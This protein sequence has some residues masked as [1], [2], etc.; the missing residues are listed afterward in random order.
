VKIEARLTPTH[1]HSIVDGT[2]PPRCKCGA[3]YYPVYSSG[4]M[5]GQTPTFK[6]QPATDP[7]GW[8]EWV[9]PVMRGYKMQCCD[10]GL[11][12]EMEFNIATTDDGVPMAEPRVEFR[13]RRLSAPEARA[14]GTPGAER[15]AD[16]S[17]AEDLK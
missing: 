12:H 5:W 13:M 3:T 7:E 8:C 9:E 2:R 17:S 4:G 1:Q 11:I 6:P 10:C 15:N 14:E 16:H